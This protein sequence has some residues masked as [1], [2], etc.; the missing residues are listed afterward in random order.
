MSRYDSIGYSHSNK[1]GFTVAELV[2]TI[3]VLAILTAISAGAYYNLQPA[4]HDSERVAD[5]AVITRSL[6]RYYQ[7]QAVATGATYPST[8][9]NTAGLALII[10][11]MDAVTAPDQSGN[12]L[13]IAT[14]GAAQTP[15]VDQY[16]YQPLQLNGSLCTVT[17]CVRYKVFYR[18]EATSNVIVRNSMRQQ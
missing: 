13:V 12:S 16:I 11:D 2:I 6:E 17:P 18:E 8:A 10:G 3:I 5:T 9:T 1:H 4:A 7:T 15:T 14:T